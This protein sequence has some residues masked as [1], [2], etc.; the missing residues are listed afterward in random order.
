MIRLSTLLRVAE[1]KTVAAYHK[2]APIVVAKYE[3]A[4]P[5]A[6][7]ASKAT[8]AKTASWLRAAADKLEG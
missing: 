1:D 2:V 4:K 5:R 6:A 3:A 8:A 7:A